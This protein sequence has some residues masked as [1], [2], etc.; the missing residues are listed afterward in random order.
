MIL[1]LIFRSYVYLLPSGHYRIFALIA[2]SLAELVIYFVSAG[3]VETE[4]D[5]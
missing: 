1:L 4:A 3:R 5:R 2:N